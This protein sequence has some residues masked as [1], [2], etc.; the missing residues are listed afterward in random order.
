MQLSLTNIEHFLLRVPIPEHSQTQLANVRTKNLLV[1]K[2]L[3]QSQSD[4]DPDR[5]G[6]KLQV[7]SQAKWPNCGPLQKL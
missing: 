1:E 6:W 3:V 4:T 2:F 7:L 5:D